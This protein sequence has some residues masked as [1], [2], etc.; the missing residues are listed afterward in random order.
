MGKST[1]YYPGQKNVSGVLQKIVN[2]IPASKHIY[3]LFAGSAAVSKFLAVG[4]SETN[5][6]IND[7][8]RSVTDRFEYPAGSIVTNE[9]AFDIIKSEMIVSAGKDTFIFLDPP[10]HHETRP[11]NTEIYK[12]EFTHW[13]HVKILTMILK[14]KCNVM[15]I[16]PVHFLYD[17]VLDHWRTIDVKI[18]YHNKTSIERI[19]MNYPAPQLL[20]TN[21]VLGNDCWDRQRIKRKGD[22]LINKLKKLPV[23]EQKY[24]IERIQKEL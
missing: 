14:L 16:H 6:H 8:D 7:I 24:L 13:D 3:E 23:L 21:A 18:R 2:E 22:R 9:N 20:Q 12:H 15:I 4:S 1:E 11:N 17:I 5:F 10:Y 19:Y